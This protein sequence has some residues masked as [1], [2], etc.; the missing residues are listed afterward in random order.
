MSV[1]SGFFNSLNGDRKY[2]AEQMSAI[3]DG[4]IN[5]GVFANIGTAFSVK[6]GT[7]NGITVGIGRAW[8]NSAWIYNDTVLPLT[9]DDAELVLARYDAVVI[10][11]D[12]SDAVRKGDIKI[13]KGNPGSSPS[14]PEMINTAYVHQYPL[15]YIY[16]AAGS[17]A[18]TQGNIEN[19]VGTSACPYITGILQVQNIDNIVSQWQG[20]W[21]EW[22]S[23]WN[24]WEALWNEWFSSQTG[25]VEADTE[26]WLAQMQTQFSAW[27][28]SLQVI[29]DGD[30]AANLTAVT[31]DLMERFRILAIERAV[32]EEMQDSNGDDLED[33]YGSV[34]EGKTVMGGFDGSEAD[35]T[36]TPESIGAAPAIHAH[37]HAKGSTDPITPGMIGAAELIHKHTW[38]DVTEKPSSFPPSTHS[39]SWEQVTGKPGTF[40]PASHTHLWDQV[41]NKP[42][43]F[44]PASHTHP[45]DQ[46]TNKPGTFTPSSHGHN[47]DD[48]SG[49][50]PIAKGG[51]GAAS[52]IEAMAKL[53]GASIVQGQYQGT[54]LSEYNDGYMNSL[55]FNATPKLLIVGGADGPMGIGIAQPLILVRYQ[56]KIEQ[57]YRSNT[58]QQWLIKAEWSGTTVKWGV[59]NMPSDV[60]ESDWPSMQYNESGTIYQYVALL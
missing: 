36:I 7:E 37:M 15:A 2:S 59:S 40:T 51:T 53:G 17:S 14:K 5:N 29:L 49:I 13:V 20:Q 47:M 45:W 60:D 34:I 43:A 41:T 55:S 28:E 54:G 6:A 57:I 35:R 48:L 38:D 30:V 56:T 22:S 52:A 23:Q 8:F 19:A 58:G 12:H 21:D 39:H 3:F 18:I 50:L 27:F 16:R 46:V 42:S 24:Q 25:E 4:I 26:E 44:T 9:A 10:E 1:T 33:S 32:Y 31:V 11:I